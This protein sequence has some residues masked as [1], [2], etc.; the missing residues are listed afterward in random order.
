MR[1]PL[2]GIKVLDL[3][4]GVAGPYCTMIL[5]DLGC[6]IVKVEKPGRG[7]A[8]RY[9]NVSDKFHAEIP[10]VGGD[11][12]LAINRNK[13]AITLEM[14]SPEGRKVCEELAAWADVVVQNFRP[15][16]TKRLGLDYESLRKFN[17]RLIYGNISAYGTEGDMAEKAGMDIAV[18]ARS[19]LLSITGAHGSKEPVRPGA[20]IADFGGGIYLTT[21]IVTALFD[22][23]RT[24]E[25]Q[26]VSVSLLDATMSM[27]INYSVA[28]MDGKAQLAPLGSGHPQLVPYQA[29][30][31]ADGHVVVATGTNK[32]YREFCVAIGEPGLADDP[33]FA[34]NQS[35]VKNREALIEK[36]SVVFRRK[37]TAQ[38]IEVLE[39]ADV[40][41]APVNDLQ[42]AFDDLEATSPGMT[43]TIDHAG[44]GKLSQLGVPFRFS[45]CAGE[46]RTPPPMLGEHTE[47]VLR[48][49]G[50]TDAQIEAMRAARVI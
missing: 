21:A 15:G 41:C 25:G 13:R 29:L 38:W 44:V 12:F 45:N 43:S 32:T 16:V 28:V 34:S 30:P 11:Y 5:G 42:T 49:L 7:D 1:R 9:M 20:S 36:L 23:E 37:T 48:E 33:M 6:E 24:G 31:T 47:Q 40:P 10:R 50:R 4:H 2:D 35:R 14:K 8:T 39:A 26:E 22:R 3:T 46:L 17:P 27:L 19:G 18:Q